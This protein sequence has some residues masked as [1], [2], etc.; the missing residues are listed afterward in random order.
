MT[1]ENYYVKAIVDGTA[2]DDGELCGGNPTSNRCKYIVS[3]T[4]PS[5]SKR[6]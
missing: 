6:R 2:I 1:E 5:C 3:K 4:G